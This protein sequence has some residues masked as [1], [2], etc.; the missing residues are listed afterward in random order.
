M[1]IEPIGTIIT[2]FEDP[3]KTPRYPRMATGVEGIVEVLPQYADGLKDLEGFERI[4]LLFCFHR[5]Q[6]AQLLVRP[7]FDE[8]N[9]RGVFATRSPQRP[10]PIG[11]SCVRLVRIQ[12]NM[13]CIQDVDMLNGT[14]LLD[15]K[16]YVPQADSFEVTRIGWFA[17]RKTGE[18]MD[19]TGECR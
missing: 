13:L 5:S 14:P 11:M 10:N 15:I 4:W 17:G 1:N 3:A 19:E 9:L 8:Q 7:P 2:P 16:P 18:A 6:G 12:G